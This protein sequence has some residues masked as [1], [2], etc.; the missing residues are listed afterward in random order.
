LRPPFV[1]RVEELLLGWSEIRN[2]LLQPELPLVCPLYAES[3]VLRAAVLAARWNGFRE[4]LAELSAG[5]LA[6]SLAQLR[7]L[8]ESARDDLWPDAFGAVFH[9][10]FGRI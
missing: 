6:R 1:A 5:T 9:N 7:P 3:R 8:V 2:G 10:C 4:V